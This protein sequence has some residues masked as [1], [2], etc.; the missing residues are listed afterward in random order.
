VKGAHTILG[1]VHLQ[2]LKADLYSQEGFIL[3]PTNEKTLWIRKISL[4][5]FMARKRANYRATHEE[6]SMVNSMIEEELQSP[7]AIFVY[8]PIDSQRR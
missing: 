4:G 7:E 8:S 2:K 3:V 5:E 6:F 1:S